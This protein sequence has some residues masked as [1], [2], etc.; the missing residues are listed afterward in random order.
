[1]EVGTPQIFNLFGEVQVLGDESIRFDFSCSVMAFREFG[2]AA[3]IDVKAHN[4]HASLGER[5]CDRQ[6]NIS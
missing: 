2:N 4:G 1:M 5:R 6:A 3:R